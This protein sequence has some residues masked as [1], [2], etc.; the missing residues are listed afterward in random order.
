MKT[1]TTLIILVLL[2]VAMWL[3]IIIG[4]T[5]RGPYIIDCSMASFHPD[6]TP[7]M[8]KACNERFLKL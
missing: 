5:S 7:E 1:V 6:Y 2:V 8:K 4:L 3:A